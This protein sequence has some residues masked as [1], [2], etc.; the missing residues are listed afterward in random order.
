MPKSRK[1]QSR[2]TRKLRGTSGDPRKQSPER[3]PERVLL[4]S[5]ILQ[6]A[7]AVKL[8]DPLPFAAL[9]PLAQHTIRSRFQDTLPPE[10]CVDDC[11]ALAHAYAE[12]GIEAQVRVAELTV[13]DVTTSA[14][15]VH[16]TPRPRW[17]D[18][19]F[20]GHAVVWLPAY[21]HLIDPA[22]EQFKEIAVY[23]A[24]PVIAAA[25]PAQADGPGADEDEV[26]VTV[27]RGYLRLAYVLGSRAA[28]AEVLDHPSVRAEWDGNRRR[29]VNVASEVVWLLANERTPTDTAMIPY[30]RAA[31][32]IDA[33]R[34]VDRHGSLGEDFFFRE[35]GADPSQARPIRLHEIP[36]PFGTPAPAAVS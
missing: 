13:T 27:V 17:E 20:S 29:G 1:R 30:P 28:S 11:L 26:K 19:V 23:K 8:S 31:A 15:T 9:P 18:G 12:L 22:A 21:R 5:A 25:G 35:R 14:K 2:L 6:K 7:A 10:R 32:L 24:G 3:I 34:E 16:G 4:A 33:A 36:L